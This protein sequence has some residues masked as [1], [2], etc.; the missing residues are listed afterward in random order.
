MK[1]IAAIASATA[2]A[3]TLAGCGA[4]SSGIAGT[5][6][7]GNISV[8]YPEGWSVIGAETNVEYSDT[9]KC[10]ELV[11]ASN[12][13]RKASVTV[14]D[15]SDGVT[16]NSLIE[17]WG[18]LLDNVGDATVDGKQIKELYGNYEQYTMSVY[19]TYDGN[20][21]NSMMS[22]TVDLESYEADPEYYEAVR[23]NVKIS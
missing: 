6:E 21:A 9:V 11:G 17:F 23:D 13:D 19:I 4:G 10:D 3:L 5:I 16:V 12:P 8:S 20:E 1:R 2:L 18:S 7:A 22:Y 15:L 14:Y